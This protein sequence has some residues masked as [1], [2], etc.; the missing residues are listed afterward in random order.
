[1]IGSVF[2]LWCVFGGI[3]FVCRCL[4]AVLFWFSLLHD[5]SHSYLLHTKDVK[6]FTCLSERALDSLQRLMSVRDLFFFEHSRTSD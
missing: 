3:V 1:M 4:L 6:F 2:G 5:P